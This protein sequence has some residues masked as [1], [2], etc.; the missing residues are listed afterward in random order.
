LQL[1]LVRAII[2]IISPMTSQPR[3][4]IEH[5]VSACLRQVIPSTL[6]ENPLSHN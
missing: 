1:K 6:N 2:N 5:G 3:P 4:V